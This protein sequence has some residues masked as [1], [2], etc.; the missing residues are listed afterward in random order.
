MKV[1]A[2][3]FD[4]GGVIGGVVRE[5]ASF[6]QR[7]AQV[8]GVTPNEFRQVYF[9]INHLVNAGQLTSWAEFDELLLSK[10]GKPEKSE[11]LAR[12]RQEFES[13]WE[14]MDERALDLIEQLKR[15]G[16]RVGLLSN[17]TRNSGGKLR[18]MGL[19]NK[20]DVFMISAEQGLQKPEPELF[21]R[22]AQELGVELNE[23]VFIDD[24]ESSLATAGQLGYTPILYR[25]YEKLVKELEN[26]GVLEKKSKNG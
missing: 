9:K 22:F 10:L 11:A 5:K 12:S 21:R 24:A 6:T 1:K 8:I 18:Q 19:E 13:N 23:L 2:I 4:Y 17:A 26:I 14:R 20:F 15:N 16:Y 3:G 7:M 25:G